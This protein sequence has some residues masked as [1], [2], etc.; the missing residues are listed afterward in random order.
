[1][2]LTQR[3]VTSSIYNIV[4]NVIGLIAGLVSAIVLTR[5]LP[6]EDFGT[7]AFVTSIV[8]ITLVLA[9]FGFH[10]A[11]LQRTGGEVGVTEE[12]LRVV[13]TLKLLFSLVWAAL[14]AGGVALF[15]P[16]H[17]RW[18]FGLMIA[19]SFIGAQLG[20]LNMLLTRRVQFRR[21]A[22]AQTA[23][24][25][26]TTLVSVGLAWR[27]WGIWALLCGSMAATAVR[28]TLLG[29]IRPVW[30]PRL[31]WSPELVRYFITFGSKVFGTELLLET[32]DRVDD[33]W[34]G[35][36]LGDKAL[37]FY[38]K[39]YGFATY[40]RQVLTNPLVQV[41]IGTYSELLN[42]RPRLSQTFAWVNMVMARANF[43]MAA[44][45]WLA[46]PEFIRLVLGDKW[47]PM[48]EAF[49]LMLLYTMFDPT[50]SMISS[51][52]ILSGAP[53]KVI[54]TRLIQLGILLAG[55][56]TPGP[57]LGIAG[58]ALAVDIMLVVG[59]TLLYVQVRRFV[60]FSLRQFY[61]IPAVA[62][63]LGLLAVYGAL[64]LTGVAGN[65]WL[66]GVVKVGVFSLGY[67]GVLLLVERAQL[68][69]AFRVLLNVLRPQPIPA[70]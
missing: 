18:V 45:L 57:L 42:N 12:V 15:A 27:G 14:L 38:D 54:H 50:K 6:P 60:D 36:V 32:L 61:C 11:F 53:E 22:L 67:A 49:R 4:A 69:Q 51:V 9:N 31:G 33:I 28:V 13:F 64:T 68:R 48:L 2:N 59:I 5:L 46:A 24:T 7:F 52:L 3:S 65:D 1:M 44:L 26:A 35:V 10:P 20:T 25:V 29:V 19:I 62:M 17:T 37:G 16:A 56:V 40:P 41:V 55:L 43:W 70:D 23:G 8:Q 21:L 30:R 58:V 63:G 34:T 66:T 47:L 39:A